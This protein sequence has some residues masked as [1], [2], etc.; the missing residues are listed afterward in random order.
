MLCWTLDR[1]KRWWRFLHPL[2]PRQARQTGTSIWSSSSLL[3]LSTSAPVAIHF[4]IPTL[5]AITAS[6]D[7]QFDNGS[8]NSYVMVTCT[9]IKDQRHRGIGYPGCVSPQPLLAQI[10]QYCSRILVLFFAVLVPRNWLHA[11]RVMASGTL[12][13]ACLRILLVPACFFFIHNSETD[14]P[15]LQPIRSTMFPS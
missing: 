3:L 14:H 5:G 13:D 4:A 11:E 10:Q 7:R 1:K 15:C 9:K 12:K 8:E 6:L 2:Q